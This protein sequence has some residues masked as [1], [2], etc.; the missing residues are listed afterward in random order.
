[1]PN[2]R[3]A[4]MSAPLLIGWVWMHRSAA[5][6]CERTSSI[7]PVVATSKFAPRSRSV[8]TTGANGM[9]FSA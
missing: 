5:T 8:A 2:L 7:S 9:G 3:A 1:M 4:A 6:R